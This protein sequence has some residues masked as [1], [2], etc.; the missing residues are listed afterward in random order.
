LISQSIHIPI[1]PQPYNESALKKGLYLAILHSQRVPPHIGLMF[2]GQYHSLTI[3]GREFNIPLNVLEKTIAQKKI[4]TYFVKVTEH[5]VF[6]IQHQEEI[7]KEI[8]MKFENVKQFQ[9]SCLSPIK[10]FFNE[11]YAANSKE[12]QLFF[13]FM[14]VLNENHFLKNFTSLEMANCNEMTLPYYTLEEL[15]ARITEERKPYFKD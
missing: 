8:L 7:F 13:E 2:E 10:L 15:N 5:P 4:A 9:A 3:K 14:Q 1:D 6:S 12:D 11:F